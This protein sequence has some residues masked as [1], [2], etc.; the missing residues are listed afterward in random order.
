MPPP[1]ATAAPPP[2]PA[3]LAF[4]DFVLDLAAERLVRDGAA[5]ALAPRYFAVLVH[6]ATSGGRLVGKD[7]LL[8]AVWGHRFV[9]DSALKVAVNAVRQALGDDSRAPRHLETVSRRGY[10]FIAA[11]RAPV[12]APAAP[13]ATPL[14]DSASR[15]VGNLP[16][17]LPDLVGRDDALRQLAQALDSHRLVT[18]HGPGGVGKT[19]LALAGAGHA[20]PPDGVW[21][22]RLD[23]L[24]DAAPLGAT[25]AR[26]VGLGHAAE[27]GTPALVRALAPM[28]LR[29]VLD[30]AEHLLA[31]VAAL[32]AALLA[33]AP[34]VQLLVTS[35]RPL[36]LAEEQVLPLRPLDVAAPPGG[37]D[38]L[39]PAL[40][41]LAQRVARLR[42]DLP[43]D[44]AA[45]A[46]IAQALDG[47]PL[48]LELAAARVP[49]LGW[50]GVGERLAEGRFTLLTRGPAG[51]PERHRTLQAALSWTTALLAPSPRRVLHRLSVMAG[52]FDIDTALAVAGDPG[53]DPSEVLDALDDL[54]DTALLVPLPGEAGP[55]AAPRWQLYDS[56][57]A[58]A[59]EGL[60]ADGDG[61]AALARLLAHLTQRFRAADE[62]FARVPQRRWTAAL[63]AEVPTLR[64]ALRRGLAEPALQGAAAALCAA[65]AQF[66]TRGGWRREA[67]ED[68][69]AVRALALP[70]LPVQVAADLDLAEAQLASVGQ[71]WP[72]PPA[73]E[74]AR[75]ARAAYAA[76]GDGWRE[77]M[78]LSFEGGLE[79]RLQ[80]D[81][82]R[83]VPLIAAQ[84]ALEAPSWGPLARRHRA[85]LEVMLCR[86]QGDLAGFER[87]CLDFAAN[88]R[89]AGDDHSAWVAAQALVQVM[90]SQHRHA[91]ALALMA[92][93][94][95]QM[96]AAGALRENA[97]V[98]AQWASLQIGLEGGDAA[99]ALLHEAV[100]MLRAEERLWWMADA[101]P[102]LPVWQGRWEAAARVQGWADGLVRARG[103]RRGLMFAD[104]R[105]RFGQ[106]LA[107]QPLAP[108][109]QALVDAPSSLDE[110]AVL[111]L[112]FG[113]EPPAGA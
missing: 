15:P 103:D 71:V 3:R 83:R 92:E 76:L 9:S 2:A 11:V 32:A 24:G 70:A 53:A 63:Q 6:L 17:A 62:D 50:A 33:G 102:W 14:P 16:Q 78:A 84:R 68:H 54:R 36:H 4:T 35:Q 104:L 22:L 38:E 43:F 52:S 77:H 8:D 99:R 89:A 110:A 87:M 105:E 18:L 44:P 23:T 56:V 7:E 57:R 75:R 12:D 45:A 49:L 85:W 96:R 27:G 25:L 1:T 112:V 46:A 13:P 10:R 60:K 100:T 59:A 34:G 88:A 42:P 31:D 82:A 5:V 79:M 109:L 90:S 48:A 21:L 37:G 30:N 86:D 106:R 94:G 20:A 113:A 98:L 58:H 26:T 61:E 73:L 65:C 107:E 111:A 51:A 40:R 91:E 74:A 69:A 39:P 101:L 95:A 108:A 67:A 29:L 55:T 97:Q 28:R 81:P 72:P 80:N 66:R 47:L 93:T 19:R 64:T 41:L